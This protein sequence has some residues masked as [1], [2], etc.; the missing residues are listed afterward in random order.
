MS[1]WAVALRGVVLGWIKHDQ[2]PDAVEVLK[3][4]GYGT[5]WDGDTEGGFYSSFY[6]SVCWRRG[7]G[8]E[9]TRD[10]QGEDM[11]SLWDWVIKGERPDA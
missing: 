11:A 2:D 7:D 5:D 4:G 3:V 1:G 8:T 9:Q 10:F 6:A